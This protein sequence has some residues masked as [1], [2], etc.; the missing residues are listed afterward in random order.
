MRSPKL[1]GLVLTTLLIAIPSPSLALSLITNRIAFDESDRVD[2][3]NL[4]TTPPF[5]FL[6]NSFEATSEKGL[7]LNVNI[8]PVS[9]SIP[10]ITPPLIFQTSSIVPTNF[11]NGDFILFTGFTPGVFPS[12]GNPGPLT[13]TFDTPVSAAG[14]QIAVDDT[15]QFTAFIS[16]FDPDNNL[17]GTFSANGTSSLALDNSAL[18]L[19]IRSDTANISRLVFSSSIPNRAFGINALSIDTPSV[20]EPSGVIALSLVGL[21]GLTR[22]KPKF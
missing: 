21:L 20:P 6:P 1:P 3:A 2:W 5:T 19:G 11:A 7:G 9:F 16:A 8:P 13:I 22:Q 15:F 14:A 12:P 4:A 18:F 10:P 17:L